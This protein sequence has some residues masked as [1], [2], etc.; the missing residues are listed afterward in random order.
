MNRDDIDI[1]SIAFIILFLNFASPRWF[2]SIARRLAILFLLLPDILR[3]C[4]RFI[5]LAMRPLP[6]LSSI[7]FGVILRLL[8]LWLHF[9]RAIYS[10]RWAVI[11]RVFSI[12]SL[13]SAAQRI[14]PFRFSWPIVRQHHIFACFLYTVTIRQLLLR[15]GLTMI[16]ASRSQA[17]IEH[18]TTISARRLAAS[19]DVSNRHY[20][21]RLRYL[22]G[23]LFSSGHTSP[24]ARAWR[25]RR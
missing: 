21:F 16:A 9:G 25:R 13:H 12:S 1:S 24:L 18:Y 6:S 19:P 8:G 20:S 22:I 2:H 14:T 17:T 7:S 3:R 10:R 4:R 23:R 5:D 11:G 15:I